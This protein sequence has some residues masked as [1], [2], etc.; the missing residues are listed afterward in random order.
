MND[1]EKSK[2]AEA[3]FI[4]GT[5]YGQKGKYEKAIEAF[6]KAIELKPDFA[7][8]YNNQGNVYDN[9]GEYD[10]A[11]EA[12]NRAIELNPDYANVY[13]NLGIAYKDKGE[14]DKAIE[15]YNKSIELSPDYAEAYN[16]LGI[17]YSDKGEYDKAIKAYNEA[18][19]LEP[20][21][22]K[23][24]NNLA[25]V[26]ANKDEWD[27]AIKAYIEAIE[28]G[29]DDAIVYAAIGNAYFHKG[30]YD[31]A[32][33][34][35]NEAIKLK[36][37]D[38]KV[39][40][41]LGLAYFNKSEYI[42]VFEAYNK[43]IKLEPAFAEA[44]N[45]L[46]I[47]YKEIGEYDKAIKAYNEAIKLKPDDAS[48]YYN[49]GSLY[50]HL[51]ENNIIF[52]GIKLDINQTFTDWN[53]DIY[54]QIHAKKSIQYVHSL[55]KFFR[56]Y[57][58]T[59]LTILEHSDINSDSLLFDIFE[60]AQHSI[61]DFTLLLQLYENVISDKR[62]FWGIKSILH[63]YL[64]GAVSSYIIFDEQLD[65]NEY[66]LSSQESYYF[67]LTAKEIN[68]EEKAILDNAISEIENKT[69]K[70][71]EDFYYLAHLYLLQDDKDKAIKQFEQSG[72]FIFSV[73]ML[74]YLSD[75][76][77]YIKRIN[78]DKICIFSQEIDYR[79]KDLL[80]FQHFFHLQECKTAVNFFIES[81]FQSFIPDKYNEPFWEV[82]KFSQLD[83]KI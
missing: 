26:Y 71:A 30:K 20:D 70:T 83:K 12:Y 73:I 40:N 53:T 48:A 28:L 81:I 35:Y 33:K 66:I 38:A 54:L 23:V 15:S 50:R 45:N 51:F 65:T 11:I 44:Y 13:N 22:A 80:Q 60:E 29:L 47:A 75:D 41:N 68:R 3:Y 39:Y 7:K 42:K 67:A 77:N 58:Q 9:K 19:K 64:G 56:V 52:K 17:V 63:Y 27:N 43:A 78:P 62:K 76:D 6:N 21:F 57:P 5:G 34:A 16:N 4:L 74:A 1:E 37:D 69:D 59:I 61:E 25:N 32:I 18:I 10:K 82:F 55:T 31:K 14:Y 72:D 79:R 36:P 49:R 46:G 2:E 24:Y 8:A